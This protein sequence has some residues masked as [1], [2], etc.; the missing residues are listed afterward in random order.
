MELFCRV[1]LVQLER[2]FSR[3]CL[4]KD[5][6]IEMSK[7]NDPRVYVGN[8]PPDIRQKELEALF[9]K[10]G[11]IV[12]VNLKNGDGRGPPF[13]FIEYDDYRDAEDAVRIKH[14][15][16]FD[17]YT[18]RVEI[19]HG[20]RGGGRAPRGGRGGSRY[21]DRGYGGS[22]GGGGGY[23]RGGY[24]SYGGG[25]GYGGRGYDDRSYGRDSDRG[26]DRGYDRDRGNGYDDRRRDR[27]PPPKR[28]YKVVVNDLPE[29]TTTDE[30]KKFMEDAGDV[31]STDIRDGKGY[32]EYSNN[33]DMRYAVKKITATELKTGTGDA[34][35]ITVTEQRESVNSRSRSRSPVNK[36]RRSPSNSP[37]RR[38]RSHS[39]T[40]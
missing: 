32:V 30:L 27:S 25:R 39:Q 21:D 22:Y 35:K 4:T 33:E 18:L 23:D 14:G 7:E 2:Q 40:P 36:R 26:Y 20:G 19:P 6:E 11:K 17:G 24:D 37:R 31:L 3:Y 1:N 8:L 13:A 29:S 28:R 10:Y 16:K 5:F 15:A 38:S 12:N 34:A 9:E